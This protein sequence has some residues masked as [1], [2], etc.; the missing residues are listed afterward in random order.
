MNLTAT[1]QAT[2]LLTSYFSSSKTNEHKPLSNTEWGRFALWLKHQRV[3]PAELLIPN[4]EKLLTGWNDPRIPLNRIVNLLGRGNS[5]AL[6][7]DKWQRAGLWIMT[8]ADADYPVR[9]KNILRNDSPPVLFG[10]GNKALLQT[11]GI[12]IV[13]SRKVAEDDLVFTRQLASN[14]AHQGITVISGGARGTD[15]GAMLAALES[16]GGSIGVL[17]DSLL[18]ATTSPKWR[19]GLMSG[20]LVLISPFY[21]EAGFSVANAMARNKYVYCLSESAMVVHAGLKGGT[22]TGALEA[23]KNQWVPVWIKP[24]QDDESANEL[25]VEKGGMWSAGRAEEID[26]QQLLTVAKT[27]SNINSMSQHDLFTL[28]E[29]VVEYAVKQARVPVDYYQLFISELPFLAAEPISLEN[30]INVTGLTL[31]QLTVWL[32]R[33]KEEGVVTQLPESDYYLAQ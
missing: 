11:G 8:R 26:C 28:Q 5:L 18:K 2:L 3:A 16:G 31:E 25:L 27:D 29:N 19:N 1:A 13:G 21:P 20:N 30:L 4:P 22:V 14:L 15:E 6:A 23:L 17:T 9:L 33:A 12:A 24:T 10:C 7:V 32:R